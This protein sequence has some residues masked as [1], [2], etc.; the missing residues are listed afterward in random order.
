MCHETNKNIKL[1]WLTIQNSFQNDS[2]S[3]QDTYLLKYLVQEDNGL[4][5]LIK[6]LDFPLEVQVC[7]IKPHQYKLSYAILFSSSASNLTARWEHFLC[8]WH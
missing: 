7:W 2:H 8:P 6:N 5:S 1:L 3:L 4:G